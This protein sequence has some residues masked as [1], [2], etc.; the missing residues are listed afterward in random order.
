[1]IHPDYRYDPRLAPA[2][3]G[4]VASGASD[5]AL[6]SRILGKGALV[7]GMPLYRYVANRFLALVPNFLC[8]QKLSEYHTGY[9]A[10][11]S[12]VLRKLPLEENSNDFIF[13][14]EIL[15]QIIYFGFR[16]GEVSIPTRYA[17]DSSSINLIRSIRYGFGVLGVSIKL[18]LQRNGIAGFRIFKP[19][20]RSLGSCPGHSDR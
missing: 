15:G 12:D 20:G 10:Y 18:F 17:G 9:R 6:G 16:I 2:L 13:D 7:G 3:A 4:M 14:N 19:A 8:G 5:V 1:M 11:S